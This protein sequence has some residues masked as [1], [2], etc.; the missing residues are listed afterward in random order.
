MSTRDA[1]PGE[2]E[3]VGA[4]W[5]SDHF[6]EQLQANGTYE[7]ASRTDARLAA[8]LVAWRDEVREDPITAPPRVDDVGIDPRPAIQ[9]RRIARRAVAVAGVLLAMSSAMA[10]ALDADP[11]KPVRYLV[12]L[13]VTVGE[14]ISDPVNDP[15][16]EEAPS[17]PSGDGYGES[18]VD[19]VL[20]PAGQPYDYRYPDPDIKPSLPGESRAAGGEAGE[21]PATT[22][23]TAEPTEENGGTDADPDASGSDPS[24]QPTESDE[25]EEPQSSDPT[26]DPTTDPTDDPTTDPTDTAPP[27]ALG[28]AEGNGDTSADGGS[29]GDNGNPQ[30]QP[31]S[32]PDGQLPGPL[33][34]GN[35]NGFAEPNGTSDGGDGGYAYDADAYGEPKGDS[36]DVYGDDQGFGEG[37]SY[38][39]SDGG[40]SV[41]GDGDTRGDD[42]YGPLGPSSL[43]NLGPLLDTNEWPGLFRHEYATLGQGPGYDSG[44][45]EWLAKA[46]PHRGDAWK[47]QVLMYLTHLR[48]SD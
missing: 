15:S 46:H 19:G 7:P 8:V 43:P 36:A 26:T 23:P 35:L 9:P 32:T 17:Q 2:P 30:D 48:R 28:E 3:S 40:G 10:T 47:S 42:G 29:G 20:P 41:S 18:D 34:G 27:P 45:M 21:L 16:A 38:G 37:E 44:M 22:D 5:A 39:E 1:L 13:G 14:R 24:E 33:D 6:I 12:D 31:A 4:I 11:L 25:T